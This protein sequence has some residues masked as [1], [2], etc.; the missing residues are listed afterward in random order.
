MDWEIL[1]ADN[2]KEWKLYLDSLYPYFDICRD[3]NVLDIG[4]Y[5]GIQSQLIR[6]YNPKSLTLVEPNKDVIESLNTHFKSENTEVVNDDIFLY[7]ETPRK[8]DVVSCCGVLYHFHS[9]LYLLELIA[10]R[11]SPAYVCIETYTNPNPTINVE[12][13]NSPGARQLKNNWKS[14]NMAIKLP[15]EIFITAMENLGYKVIIDTKIEKESALYGLV[16]FWIF[17]KI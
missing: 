2:H 16:N 17:E 6:A 7:L 3:K 4:P 5:I 9:P 1:Y 12:D 13:D 8:F 15:R 10:N 11:I 14:V